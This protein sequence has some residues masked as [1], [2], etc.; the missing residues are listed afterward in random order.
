MCWDYKPIK[1]TAIWTGSTGFVCSIRPSDFEYPPKKW[2]P[3]PMNP[4][5]GGFWMV[6]RGTLDENNSKWRAKGIDMDRYTMIYHDSIHMVYT[7]HMIYPYDIHILS[8]YIYTKQQTFL[9]IF[10][11]SIPE[12]VGVP[13]LF[14][15]NLLDLSW[16]RDGMIIRWILRYLTA[17]LRLR[18]IEFLFHKLKASNEAMHVSYGRMPASEML[19]CG[20]GSAPFGTT[21]RTIV[22]CH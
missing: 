18:L 12:I 17:F 5:F 20:F 14:G 4:P 6:P 19:G 16:S 3:G 11:Q 13:T 21:K 10:Q 2:A 8:I 9:G 7:K 22:V 15:G 1:M